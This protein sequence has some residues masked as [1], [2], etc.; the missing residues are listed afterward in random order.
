MPQVREPLPF[1]GSRRCPTRRTLA[2]AYRP[3]RFS[4]VLGQ[5]APIRALGA[6]AERGDVAAAYIFSGTRGIGKTTIARIFAKAL[7]CERG[8]AADCC[9]ECTPCREIAEGRSLDVV[10]LDAATHTGIDDIRELREA[11]QYPPGRDRYRVFILDEAHQLSQAAWNGLLKI[12]EEPPSWC[13]FLFC[14]TEP[15]RI[16]A[17]IESRALHF[18]FRSPPPA[19]LAAH[20]RDI[21]AREEIEIDDGAIDLLV[22]AANGS[23]RDGL[24][25]LDQVRAVADGPIDADLV[26]E[27]LGLVPGE[28]VDRWL[29][30][31]L[32]GDAAAALR[33]VAEL[34]EEGQ[35]LRAFTAEALAAVHRVG[36][37]RA[38]GGDAV[39]DGA[40]L[41][42]LA[43]KLAPEQVAFAG[44]V[45]DET[46]ARLRAGGPQ[47]ILLDLATLRVA[48][49]AD[50]SPL[51]DLAGRALSGG[52]GGGRPPGTPPVARGGPG[53]TERAPASGRGRPGPS[54]SPARASTPPS[55]PPAP[56]PADGLL[57][58]LLDEVAG[59]RAPVAAYLRHASGAR[60]RE[61]GVLEITLP[62]RA[63]VWESRLRE[64]AAAEALR[65]AAERVL[66]HPPA[67][68]EIRRGGGGG[69]SAGPAGT[70]PSPRKTRRQ[71]LEQVRQDPVIREIFDRFDAVLLDGHELP[72]GEETR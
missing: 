11:A 8:P 67:S 3:Q 61:D 10:E 72:P 62:A 22:R 54:A 33:V 32:G 13:V 24:S 53:A 28:A 55:S 70:P 30:A 39:P 4:E 35:D 46:E 31:A 69:G 50:L 25:A 14:T 65:T 57:A 43:G 71:V 7:N 45:L 20:L 40:A 16:P 23:V 60:L 1:S 51:A 6:A 42:D 49:A 21:A 59:V 47:R 15:H 38:L 18:A 68:V 34:D 52:G 66:G 48:R 36:L 9:G 29:R 44:K 41:V 17:T 19:A 12:L 5:R 2:T 63:V 56:P 58:R 27:A 37:V 26:R 64:S